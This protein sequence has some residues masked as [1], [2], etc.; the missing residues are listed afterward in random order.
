MA[1]RWA[2]VRLVVALGAI[3]L[4]LAVSGCATPPSSPA[5]QSVTVGR[6]VA[7]QN[8]ARTWRLDTATGHLCLML[9]ESQDAFKGATSCVY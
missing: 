3:L 6:Y 1:I 9:A 5:S 2:E 8:G 4:T 7:V